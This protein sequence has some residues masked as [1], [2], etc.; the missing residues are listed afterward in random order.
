[1]T[2]ADDI[3]TL[4]RDVRDRVQT[5]STEDDIR[6][7]ADRAIDEINRI[8]DEAVGKARQVNTLMRRLAELLENDDAQQP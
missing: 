8:A 3:R 7:L 6:G 4:A 5:A 1:M 2:D